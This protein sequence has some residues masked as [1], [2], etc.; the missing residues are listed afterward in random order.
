MITAKI[1]RTHRNTA[2]KKMPP[3]QSAA[4][5]APTRPINS[6]N[7]AT[8]VATMHRPRNLAGKPLASFRATPSRRIPVLCGTVVHVL[9]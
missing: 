2:K 4:I 9:R 8:T 7:T 5:A 6:A 1:R 3:A